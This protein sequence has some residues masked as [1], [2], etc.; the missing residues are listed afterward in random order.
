MY[1]RAVALS[2]VLEPVADLREREARLLG[3]VSLLV[4]RWVAVLLVTLL[5]RLTRFLLE[6]VDGLLAVP[7]GLGQRVLPPQSVLIHRAERSPS[8]LLSLEVMRL[9]PELL[10]H[11][12][13][14]R[15]EVVALQNGVQLSETAVVEGDH[16]PGF[17]HGLTASEELARRERPEE[18]GESVDVPALLQS[19]AHA[20]HLLGRKS[21]VLARQ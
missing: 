21:Q 15:V 9:V 14:N 2:P 3:Q 19:F 18:A 17:E 11:R 10:E 8:D 1:G 12:V 20:R 16:G 4:R 13:V 5:Q 7:D 6:A